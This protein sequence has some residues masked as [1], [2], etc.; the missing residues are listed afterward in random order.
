MTPDVVAQRH[1]VLRALTLR[2]GDR[3]L[4]IGSGPGLLAADMGVAVGPSGRV[5]GIDISES[6]VT[7]SRA[8]C[9]SQS[10]VEFNV[11]NA[12]GLPFPDSA[13]DVAVSTQVYEYLSH[14]DIETA[15]AELHRVL[16]PG[17][18]ALILDTDGDSIVWYSTDPTRMARV[19]AAWEEHCADFHL[20][21]KLSAKLLRA[22]FAIQRRDTVSLFNPEY[23]PNTYSHGL[24]DLIVAFVPGRHGV[25]HQEAKTWADDL[26]MLGEKGLYFFSLNRYLFLVTKS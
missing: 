24:I 3:V 13:F 23:D 26:R 2:A 9:A 14:D 4:D 8:R 19:L 10:Q 25:T 12:R 16:R 11:A 6:M 15:L 20:P 21:P 7:I 5:L 17:G 1:E 22:G 18:R